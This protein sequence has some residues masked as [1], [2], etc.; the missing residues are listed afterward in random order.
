MRTTI[1]DERALAAKASCGTSAGPIYSL[2]L[3]KAQET[4]VS[5]TVLDFG[6]GTGNLARLL[7]EDKNIVKVIASDIVEY[8]DNY[9]HPKLEWTFHDL[10]YDITLKAETVDAIFAVE[11]IE[12]LE[13]PRHLAR[14]WFRVL[15]PGGHLLVSTPNN[16][17]WRSILSLVL[18]SHFSAF[19]G[20]SYP[21][22]IMALLRLDLERI[23]IEAGFSQVRFSFTDNG[24]LPKF[25][26][27]TWQKCSSG[28]LKGLRY[29]DNLLCVAVKPTTSEGT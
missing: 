12:H 29:S 21:A 4:H 23:F 5:G 24:L 17:S 20:P 28:L 18:K 25:K 8:G 26:R 9:Q 1:T 16:E 11:V 14:E 27:M 7:C 19:T 3:N 2:V 10:N 15:K 13:N 6:A 22:H